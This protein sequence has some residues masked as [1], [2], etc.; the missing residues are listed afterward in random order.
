MGKLILNWMEDAPVGLFA[1]CN[2]PCFRSQH[3]KRN[4]WWLGFA[5]A[6]TLPP[7]AHSQAFLSTGFESSEGY[8]RGQLAGQQGWTGTT[9]AVVEASTVFAG[10]QA[11]SIPATGLPAQ[12]F[13][14]SPPLTISSPIVTLEVHFMQSSSGTASLWAPLVALS[15]QGFMAQVLVTPD[16]H[17]QLGLASTAV[18]NV[19]VGRGTWNDYQ[20]VINSQTAT[21][22]AYVNSQL[23]GSGPVANN[24]NLVTAELQLNFAPGTDTGYFDQLFV[25]PTSVVTGAYYTNP[26]PNCP[27]SQG[28]AEVDDASGQTIG[29]ACYVSGTF[30]WFA[31]GGPP[32]NPWK[33]SIRV[34]APETGAIKAEY[35]FF[36]TSGNS[37]FLDSR[38]GDGTI[39]TGAVGVNAILA[40][41]E[42]LELDLLGATS[43]APSYNTTQ[44]GSVFAQFFCPDDVTCSK[45]GAQLVYSALPAIPWSLSVPLGSYTTYSTTYYAEGTDDGGTHRVSFVVYNNDPTDTAFTIYVYD[46]NGNLAGTGVTPTIPGFNSVWHQGGTYGALL[47]QVIPGGLPSGLFKVVF[48]GGTAGEHSL[49]EVLQIDGASATTLQVYTDTSPT[50]LPASDVRPRSKKYSKITDASRSLKVGAAQS[51]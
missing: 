5:L 26:A 46:S 15:P 47:S 34:A 45:V 31:A 30:V 9:A 4:V 36:D 51:H 22:T 33:S 41:N 10:S 40:P 2:K 32:N 37:V 12:T 44:T 21:V 16:G 20:M 3:V 7:L 18:G 27:T 25:T 23:I 28:V 13:V 19:P 8:S 6:A 48:D 29:Y 49:V 17:A 1:I 35:L 14:D 38:F 42:P 11:V 24:G 43:S 50:L 39:M